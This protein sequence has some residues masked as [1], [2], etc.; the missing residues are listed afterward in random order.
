MGPCS[1]RR[2]PTWQPPT[3]TGRVGHGHGPLLRFLRLGGAE[4]ARSGGPGR[5]HG[6]TTDEERPAPPRPAAPRPSQPLPAP[7]LRSVCAR[8][9]TYC[10]APPGATVGG[11]SGPTSGWCACCVQRHGVGASRVGAR[12]SARACERGWRR[13][14]GVAWPRARECARAEGARLGGPVWP[15]P[16]SRSGG[17]LPLGGR[18]PAVPGVPVRTP[19]GGAR[20]ARAALGRAVVAKASPAGGGRR[21]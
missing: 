8:T 21:R 19:C 2:C 18:F 12:A 16:A 11:I 1:F 13:R 4:R 10:S 6:Q 3:R 14:G 15:G 7:R 9:G 20:G 5:I 17:R